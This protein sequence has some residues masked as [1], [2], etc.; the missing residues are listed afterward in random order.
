MLRIGIVD[1][2]GIVRAGFR[3]MLHSCGDPGMEVTLEAATGEEALD[4]LEHIA[5]DVLLLDISLPGISGVDV[6]QRL[7]ER[8]AQ[9][10]VLILSAHPEEHYAPALIRHGAHGYLCKD[11]DARQ[12][13]QAIRT[14]AGGRRYLSDATAHLLAGEV[15][16]G[17]ARPPHQLL[18]ERELQV[19]LRLARGDSVTAIARQLDLS[20]KTVSTYRT[21]LLEK[22]GVASNAELASYAVRHGLLE[23]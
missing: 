10:R 8:H 15:A 13:V 20:V 1:D 12:L 18:S 14:V 16:A 21:R 5:C 22:L 4:R 6:L 19:F 17:G 23:T 9:L 11:C 3:E 7:R 2:H